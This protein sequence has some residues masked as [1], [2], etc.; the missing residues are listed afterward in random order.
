MLA[1]LP[2]LL[3]VLCTPLQSL[4]AHSAVPEGKFSQ[5]L[6]ADEHRD[7]GEVAELTLLQ[8][9]KQEKL[10]G[11]RKS[12]LSRAKAKSELD[13]STE[14]TDGESSLIFFAVVT[15]LIVY[16]IIGAMFFK[17]HAVERPLVPQIGFAHPR[18]DVERH[19]LPG[20][21]GKMLGPTRDMPLKVDSTLLRRP[22]AWQAEVQSGSGRRMLLL[23]MREQPGGQRL[24]DIVDSDL[25]GSILASIKSDCLEVLGPRGSLFGRLVL[26]A[27]PAK[28]DQ[29]DLQCYR[30][31]DIVGQEP[32][33]IFNFDATRRLCTS[34]SLLD[35][36]VLSTFALGPTRCFE[37]EVAHD[38]DSILMLVCSLG[39]VAFVG[40]AGAQGNEKVGAQLPQS[41]QGR[42]SEVTDFREQA[43]PEFHGRQ[44]NARDAEPPIH[45]F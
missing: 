39:L 1:L 6:E 10:G 38:V 29:S 22:G 44:Q 21:S 31:E 24:L 12:T 20:L 14:S 16:V 5:C 2:L 35:G 40:P 4:A 8:V 25:R 18:P 17:S 37:L 28:Q 42:S 15:M 23:N 30:L 9:I 33:V 32:K 13:S 26:R 43:G 3:T 19:A 45:P 41:R 11:S 7:D 36:N 34:A 27:P